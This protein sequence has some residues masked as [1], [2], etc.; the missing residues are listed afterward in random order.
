MDMKDV[1]K[2]VPEEDVKKS[3]DTPG[4]EAQ[5]DQTGDPSIRDQHSKAGLNIGEEGQDENSEPSKVKATDHVSDPADTPSSKSEVAD[6]SDNSAR[7]ETTASTT[8][9][10][11]IK[12]KKSKPEKEPVARVD[13]AIVAG[14]PAEE[15]AV[16][17]KHGSSE[18]NK[19]SAASERETSPEKTIDKNS[20]P[21]PDPEAGRE[22]EVETPVQKVKEGPAGEKKE[23][24]EPV[25]SS[26][27]TDS[28][29][30][31]V[32]YTKF[33]MDELVNTLNIL[34]SDRPVDEIKQDVEY[35]KTS[36]YKKLKQ[37]TAQKQAQFLKEGG[38]PE[39]F[40][41][42]PNPLEEQLKSLLNQ[43]RKRRTDHT[44]E[45][46]LQKQVNLEEKY[47]IIEAI[48]GLINKE[49]S[50]NKTFQDFRDL[51]NQWRSV[52]PVP[53]SKL[54]HL[55]ENYHYH[56]EKFYDYIKI[57]K[58]LRDLDLKKNMEAKIILCEKTEELI[59][60]PNVVNA[61]KILQKFHDQWREIGPVPREAKDDL[62]ER[63]RLAT[64][65]INKRHQ[66]HF[67]DLKLALKKNLEEKTKLCESVEEILTQEI[68]TH[69]EWETKSRAVID[70]QR[71]WKTIGFAPKKH[72]TIIYDRFRKACDTFFENKR[73]FYTENKEIQQ[74]NLQLK[75]ELCI[76]AEAMKESQEWKKTT[77]D[78]IELQKKWKEIGPV[79]KKY[80]DSIWKRFRAACDTFFKR[81][82]EFYAT[83]DQKYEDNLKQKINLVKDIEN[84]K[85]DDSM[86]E[87]VKQLH[88]FQRRWSE[89]GYVPMKEK[90]AIMQQYRNAINKL[91]ERLDI[92]DS[93]VA[94]L[95][96][97]TKLEGMTPTG[98]SR[99]KLE[100]EREKY[101]NK[102][103]KLESDIGVWENNIGF[104]TKS[105]N[106]DSMIKE[107]THKIEQA[108]Q[109]I[110]LLDEKV[111]MIDDL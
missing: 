3:N 59:L 103:K 32:D 110:K 47:K 39:D 84:H 78:L 8:P 51:Q 67:E 12:R 97:K 100:S 101:L 21:E 106:A 88:E 69:K 90:N 79:P 85:I 71:V 16:P 5:N 45:L 91:I 60:E 36:F 65:K 94:I 40:Q 29:V 77:E 93:K 24:E 2:D 89:I 102:I 22:K 31:D 9:E 33:S 54:K 7:T 99:S 62:W 14:D 18:N 4:Q 48:E 30:K 68:K 13:D 15:K 104:F 74:N 61:F 82:S 86:D 92:D 66:K 105:E 38:A 55:W 53:Q 41:P 57:N 63:F 1:N 52:G 56:V 43:F 37:E 23:D 64:S 96:F 108:K 34:V 50:I 109:N 26:E 72:N 35:I 6:D 42:G 87:N 98:R 70:I 58:E 11:G 75:T 25:S 73:A 80:S 10:P 28:E 44:R 107:F 76:Q 27:D 111:K 95:K 83:I 49:E 81:K 17:E 20:E 19:K 46:E